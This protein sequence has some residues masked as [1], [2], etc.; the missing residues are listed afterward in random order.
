M[1]VAQRQVLS[2]SLFF[3]LNSVVGLNVISEYLW[4]ALIDPT[5]KGIRVGIV[6]IHPWYLRLAPSGMT[7]CLSLPRTEGFPGRWYFEC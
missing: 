5:A 7:D 4:I 6:T 2:S 3:L 1:A